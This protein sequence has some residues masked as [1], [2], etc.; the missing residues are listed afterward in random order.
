MA[1]T[2]KLS[3]SG[4]GILSNKPRRPPMSRRHGISQIHSDCPSLGCHEFGRARPDNRS[5]Y[6]LPEAG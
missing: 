6:K 3:E 1:D 5:S 4:D 2:S